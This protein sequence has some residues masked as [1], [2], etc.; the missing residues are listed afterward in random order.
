MVLVPCFSTK[1][2]CSFAW[3]FEPPLRHLLLEHLVRLK[4]V[5]I[6][7]NP[8]IWYSLCFYYFFFYWVVFKDREAYHIYTDFLSVLKILRF[9]AKEVLNLKILCKY[10]LARKFRK[11][12]KTLYPRKIWENSFLDFLVANPKCKKMK[13]TS[14]ASINCQ[15]RKD[16]TGL[17]PLT[18]SIRWKHK[19]RLSVTR[20][21]RQASRDVACTSFQAI[22]HETRNIWLVGL[23]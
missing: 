5:D 14:L 10:V 4:I 6:G 23:W 22:N 12:S 2:S 15:H 20:C 1:C 9:G 21:T 19:K 17:K 8:L 18:D 11:N 3:I 13:L 7:L 16:G